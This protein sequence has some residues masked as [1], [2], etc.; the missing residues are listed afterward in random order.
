MGCFIPESRPALVKF[1]SK[2]GFCAYGRYP[3]GTQGEGLPDVA[4]QLIRRRRRLSDPARR[5]GH[6]SSRRVSGHVDSWRPGG[7]GALIPTASEPLLAALPG[8]TVTPDASVSVKAAPESTGPHTPSDAFLQETGSTRLAAGGD[9]GQGVTVAVL[10]TGIANLPDFSGR[11]VGGVDLTSGRGPY[12]DSYGHGTFV[13]GL[14]AGNG[15]SS[16]GQYSGEAPG[17]R[18]GSVKV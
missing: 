7:V 13:A 6:S 11:L 4:C 18:L 1:R 8:I 12:Q 15:A 17:A 16:G 5:G 14:I 9:T 2:A 10:D 3:K